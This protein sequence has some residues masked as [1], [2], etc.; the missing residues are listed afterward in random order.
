MTLQRD[1]SEETAADRVNRPLT[2]REAIRRLALVGVTASP[3]AL[4]AACSSGRGGWPS[5]RRRRR[6]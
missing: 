3:T 6:R 1:N 5:R 2:R 4:I